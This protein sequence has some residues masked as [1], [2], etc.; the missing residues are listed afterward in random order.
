MHPHADPFALFAT[1]F[2][3]A[4]ATEPDVPDAMQ[5]ATADATGRPHLR[6]VLLKAHGPDGFLFYTN[7]RSTK[8]VQL[9]SMPFVEGLLHWKSHA[10]QVRLSGHVT[11]LDD[12]T[13]DAYFATRARGS[14]LG[15]WASA[16]SSELPSRSLLEQR[17]AE[18]TARFA[19]EDV[20]R[21]PFWSGYRIDVER[22]E[23]WQGRRDR[24]HDRWIYERDGD[25][26][27]THLLYP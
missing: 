14:Q 25:A 11:L 21:P 5:I 18:V 8:A 4:K 16:Q 13:A 2:E 17:L 10:R 26:W 6:T 19:G 9:A 24:L 23:F 20:P 3:E 27:R 1:W 12:A 15:A 7:L 22:F